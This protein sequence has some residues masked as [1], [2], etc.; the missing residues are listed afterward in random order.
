[1][2]HLPLTDRKTDK[3]ADRQK[4]MTVRNRLTFRA[5]SF[6][7]DYSGPPLGSGRLGFRKDLVSQI[8]L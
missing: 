1:M 2:T 3:Q 4:D 5:N 8:R 7:K 6:R